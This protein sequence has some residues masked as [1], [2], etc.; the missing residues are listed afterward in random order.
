M[1]AV[2]HVF[3]GVHARIHVYHYAVPSLQRG[4]SP[5]RLATE[6]KIV[7]FL[8]VSHLLSHVQLLQALVDTYQ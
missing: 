7:E 5:Q 1:F 8:Q 3:D 2:D 4:I 6:H